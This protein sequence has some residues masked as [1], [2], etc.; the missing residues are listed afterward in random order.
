[1][2]YTEIDGR[3]RLPKMSANT[4]FFKIWCDHGVIYG[5]YHGYR[6]HMEN[7]LKE[8]YCTKLVWLEPDDELT[9]FYQKP[10]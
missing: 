4:Y 7:H 3:E 8:S 6:G 10:D 1:M 5:Y 2:K 9:D